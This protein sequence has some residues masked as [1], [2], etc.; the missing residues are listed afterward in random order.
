[1]P[2]WCVNHLSIKCNEEDKAELEAFVERAK[3]RPKGKQNDQPLWF[4]NFVPFPATKPGDL[5]WCSDCIC[6]HEEGKECAWCRDRCLKNWGTKWEADFDS[7]TKPEV[8]AS[9]WDET[10]LSIKYRFDTAW[11][12]PCRWLGRVAPLFP[13][14]TFE[15][16]YLEQGMGFIGLAV[17]EGGKKT[18]DEIL[19][20][21]ER[22]AQWIFRLLWEAGIDSGKRR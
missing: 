15:L 18:Y 20:G 16:G 13:K 8:T 9:K 11:S 22:L 7:K 12:P 3:Q 21:E 10:E 2:N 1:M 5:E 4:A 6:H 19:G 17:H 14:L